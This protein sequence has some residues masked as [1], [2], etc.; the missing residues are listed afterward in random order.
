MGACPQGA[1][2]RRTAGG[3][4]KPDSPTNARGARRRRL[5]PIHRANNPRYAFSF[6]DSPLHVEAAAVHGEGFPADAHSPADRRDRNTVDGGFRAGGRSQLPRSPPVLPRR[7]KID[8]KRC[9]RRPPVLAKPPSGVVA[10]RPALHR[11]P[12]MPP[13][14]GRRRQSGRGCD[15]RFA[16]TGR[17]RQNAGMTRAGIPPPCPPSHSLGLF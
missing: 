10:F 8:R 2:V 6:G 15:P 17:P 1:Y 16:P 5:D 9:S 11:P 13:A 4:M 7:A 12:A 3:T 14:G